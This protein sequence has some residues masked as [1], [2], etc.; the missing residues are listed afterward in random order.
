M[1]LVLWIAMI[2]NK[3]EASL[4]S[5]SVPVLST[6]TTELMLSTLPGIR[7]SVEKS[8]EL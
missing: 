7:I 3:K 6:E 8:R 4:F 1:R 2:W 5:L